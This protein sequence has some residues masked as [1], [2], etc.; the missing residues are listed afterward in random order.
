MKPRNLPKNGPQSSPVHITHNNLRLNLSHLQ[1]PTFITDW[2]DNRILCFP[3]DP[4]GRDR[5]HWRQLWSPSIFLYFLTIKA[6]HDLLP[7]TF[8]FL[9]LP[10][11]FLSVSYSDIHPLPFLHWEIWTPGPS[12]SWRCPLGSLTGHFLSWQG[13]RL[14][15]PGRNLSS[16]WPPVSQCPSLPL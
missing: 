8:W 1:P 14:F 5:E 16:A 4:L 12:V 7:N 11:L 2:L 13:S 6:T 15:I 9:L 3:F 10:V